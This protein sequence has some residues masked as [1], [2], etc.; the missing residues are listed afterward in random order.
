MKVNF[1][2]LLEASCPIPS[3]PLQKP[4]NVNNHTLLILF[5]ASKPLVILKGGVGRGKEEQKKKAGQMW[6][7]FPKWQALSF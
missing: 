4:K 5:S 1:F 2:Y 6:E 7:H 3:N